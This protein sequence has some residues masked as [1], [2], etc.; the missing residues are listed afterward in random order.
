MP[1]SRVSL[2]GI[3]LGL[4]FVSCRSPNAQPS[5][6]SDLAASSSKDVFRDTEA[7]VF[8]HA[9]HE[10]FLHVEGDTFKK[11]TDLPPWGY[12]CSDEAPYGHI[13]DFYFRNV[14]TGVEVKMNN[15][16]IRVKG[17]TSCDDPVHLR[18]FKVKLNP[19]DKVSN[20]GK[21]KLKVY[22]K[23][24]S[25]LNYP[26]DVAAQI[27][28]QN[29]FGLE[30]FGLRRG[31]NDPSRIRDLLASD[32]FEYGGHLA[33]KYGAEGAPK[34]AGPVYRGSVA[35]VKIYNGFGTLTEGHMGLVELVDGDLIKSHY[36]KEALGNLFKIREG[37]GTFLDSEMPANDLK[38]LLS[39][40]DPKNIDGKEFDADDK[41]Q[42]KR[43]GEILL[44][45]RKLLTDA[46]SESDQKKRRQELEKF[47]DIDNLLSY[48]ASANLTGHWDSL[49][50]S[51]SNNDFLFMNQ[52]TKKWGILTWDLDN[53]FGGGNSGPLWMAGIREFNVPLKY[54][55]LFKAVLDNYSTEYRARVKDYLEGIFGY[56]QMNERITNYRNQITGGAND[57]RYELIYKFYKHRFAN[58]WCQVYADKNNESYY[59]RIENGQPKMSEDGLW[60]DCEK[61]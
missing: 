44:G 31:G 40:Y 50:G 60:V 4:A 21:R 55:P 38:R 29:L 32:V 46:L 30:E 23:F 39:Y 52:K 57:D 11:M 6:G 5:A 59:T 35:Y 27:K 12:S 10:I 49:V 56:K 37:K 7:Q 9:V 25:P 58:A 2:L 42:A 43:A 36:G 20:D 24:G 22:E 41:N 16:G 54:R 47:L 8:D 51:T 3:S 28:D 61:R 53:T 19:L 15:A 48:I 26:S 34:H 33:R 18:G 17:N 13:K 45:F 1:T 14:K